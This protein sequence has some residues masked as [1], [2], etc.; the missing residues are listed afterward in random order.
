[1]PTSLQISPEE[2]LDVLEHGPAVLVMEAGYA[3]GGS[4]PP[5]HYHPSQ[6][7]R[8]DILDGVL[9]VEVAGVRRDL[10]TGETIAIPRGTPHR[11]WNPFAQPARVRWETRPAG[12]TEEWF[13]ALAA[14]QGTRHVDARGRPKTLPFAALAHAYRDTFR[15]AGPEPA[16]RIAIPALAGAA[17]ATRRAPQQAA[18]GDLGALSGPLAGIAFVGA[19]A[20]GIAVAKAPYPRP[21]AK[22]TDV[23]RYFHG[24]DSAA[25]ISAAGQ[26]IS[27]ASLARF[28]ASVA[29]L[30]NQPG[31]R[32][33]ALQL[34]AIASGGAATASLATSAA[35]GLALTGAAGRR[36]ATATALHRR[37]FLTGGP[38]HTAAFG[39]LVGCLSLAGRRTGRLPRPLTI[40]GLASA[41]AGLLSPLALVSKP[42][43][44]LIPA[45]RMSGL[46]VI[47]VAGT[48]LSGQPPTRATANAP[49]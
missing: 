27:A 46:V 36:K 43:V 34:G 23:R 1:M 24:S 7:E 45:G 4:A 31:P 42:G 12:R 22:A 11:M 40:A 35:I 17:R 9:R 3:P 19:L 37:L 29:R 10:P 41:A 28:T 26:L 2:R 15:I 49:H 30:A 13:T 18:R 47:A 48:M 16:T 20:T 38:L 39:S 14:L 25:R 8:F 33:R 6:D 21:G 32:S 44:L 5:T